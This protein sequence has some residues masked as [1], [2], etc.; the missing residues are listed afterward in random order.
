M[1]KLEEYLKDLQGQHE[2]AL[3]QVYMIEGAMQT[4]RF[5]I[6]EKQKEE[7]DVEAVSQP[8]QTQD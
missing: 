8:V 2:V 4:V 7:K 6:A 5:L 3:K 1:D